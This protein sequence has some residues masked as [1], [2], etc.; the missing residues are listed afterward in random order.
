MAGVPGIAFS[1]RIVYLFEIVRGLKAMI[2]VMGMPTSKSKIS[3]AILRWC[4]NTGPAGA[5]PWAPM[6]AIT[7]PIA[8]PMTFW[9]SSRGMVKRMTAVVWAGLGEA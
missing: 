3:G 7:S 6:V 5:M 4:E 2:G 9:I 1:A 8:G